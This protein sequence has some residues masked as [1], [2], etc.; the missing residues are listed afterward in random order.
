[1]YITLSAA[2]KAVHVLPHHLGPVISTAPLVL[3]FFCKSA[4]QTLNLSA[5]IVYSELFSSFIPNFS[6]GV[7]ENGHVFASVHLLRWIMC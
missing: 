1:M 5:K 7:S 2:F 4:S 6:G 3:N